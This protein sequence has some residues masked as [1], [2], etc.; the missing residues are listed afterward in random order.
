MAQSDKVMFYCGQR[1]MRLETLSVAIDFTNIRGAT[2]S[3][4]HWHTLTSPLRELKAAVELRAE[5][6]R[7]LPPDF[8]FTGLLS[9]TASKDATMPVDNI[10][11]LYSIAKHLGWH[12]P[13]QTI[14]NQLLKYLSRRPNLQYSPI[15][16]SGSST[17]Q[18]VQQTSGVFPRGPPISANCHM[19]PLSLLQILQPHETAPP[20][21]GLTPLGVK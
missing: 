11:G 13:Y 19:V 9:L 3:Q 20:S 2:P 17:F 14:T 21:S 4:L 10:F 18:V 15:N 1:M 16:L 7:R 12:L 6:R 5:P 8:T